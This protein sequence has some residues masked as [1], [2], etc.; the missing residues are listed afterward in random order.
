M[1]RVRRRGSERGSHSGCAGSSRRK[2]GLRAKEGMEMD[3]RKALCWRM[4]LK[5]T[6]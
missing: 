3:M 4:S 5:E 2:R 1:R 6:S